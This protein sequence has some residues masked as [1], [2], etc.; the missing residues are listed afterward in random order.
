M[1]PGLISSPVGSIVR[2]VHRVSNNIDP[3]KQ[4]ELL[5]LGVVVGIGF[6]TFLIDESSPSWEGIRYLIDK[7][8]CIDYV[9]T[10][11]TAS[12]LATVDYLQV[13][14]AWHHG[15]PQPEDDFPSPTYDLANYCQKCG[16]GK[17]QNAPFRMKR[18]PNWGKKH[19][20]QLNW[21]FDEFFV[22]PEVWEGVFKPIGIGYLPVVQHRTG[23]E[24]RTVVQL[25]INKM[26]QL[27]ALIEEYPSKTCEVCG[28]KKYLPICRGYFPPFTT[29]P[30]CQLCRTREYFGSGGSAWNATIV[31]N[32]LYRVLLERKLRGVVFNAMSKPSLFCP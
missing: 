20:L 9:E 29:D 22:L 23:K 28:H 30:S 1:V 6:E 7:W 12:E 13:M 15:Y 24:L 14:P 18:E 5:S 19:I 31:A 2:I 26:V 25:N 8:H 10:K 4:Q 17:A 32:Q 11:F 3:A 27:D 16:I 21:V